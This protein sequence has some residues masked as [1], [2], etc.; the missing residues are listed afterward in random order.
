MRQSHILLFI[1]FFC[2]GMA[3]TR[4]QGNKKFYNIAYY[5]G[6]GQA[7]RNHPVEKLTHII[8]SFLR[9]SHDTLTFRNDKQRQTVQDL[10]ALKKEYPGLKIMVS[11]GGWGGCAPCSELFSSEEHRSTFART[12]VALFREYGIDGLDLDWEYPTIE[13]Y[14]GHAYGP[15]DKQHF[16]ELVRALRKEM[17]RDFLLSFAA[18][19]FTKYLEE[20]VDWNALVPLV[21]FINL[22]TYDLTNGYSKVTGHHT[23]LYSNE[24]QVESSDHCVSWLI[25]HGIPADKLI[26]G[27]AFYARV[28]E[29]VPDKANGLYQPGSFK[30]GVPYRNFGQYFSGNSGFQYFWDSTAHAPW[31]YNSSKKLFA[32][33]DDKRSIRDKVAYVRQRHLGGIMFWE[34]SE[35]AS[36]NGLVDAIHAAFAE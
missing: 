23:P 6:D 29:Q 4:A 27:A 31:Q 20:S 5:T 2:V 3:T 19:G 7:I 22:M 24:Q 26:L 35:D 18:G 1:A 14:P 9:L 15:E 11:L 8:Y 12:T 21:D 33:F 13:G 36:T 32:T 25:D 16:T 30:Q 17:G 10:V 34:L 28:W